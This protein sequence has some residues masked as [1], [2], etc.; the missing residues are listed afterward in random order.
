MKTVSLELAKQLKEEGF[1]QETE[2][3]WVKPYDINNDY[4]GDEP[5]I[6]W[7]EW[8]EHVEMEKSIICAAPTAEEILEKLPDGVFVKEADN[9]CFLE[10]RKNSKVEYV[11]EASYM[12]W[13][14]VIGYREYGITLAEAAGKMWLYL[15]ENKLI[16]NQE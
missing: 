12:D 2:F 14:K 11:F 1:P 3:Y 7:K 16:P 15:K 4:T 8:L 10:I 9:D 13:K 6:D 5:V